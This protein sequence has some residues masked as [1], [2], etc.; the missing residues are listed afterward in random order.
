[1]ANRTA[2]VNVGIKLM[3]QLEENN[4]CTEASLLEDERRP[5]TAGRLPLALLSLSPV[6]LS[7]Q[8]L[9]QVCFRCQSTHFLLIQ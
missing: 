4:E 9:L 5:A 1:M 8:P 6:P 2:K 7:T 3:C